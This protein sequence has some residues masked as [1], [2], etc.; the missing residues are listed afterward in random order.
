MEGIADVHHH[1]ALGG[2]VQLGEDHTVEI[3]GLLERQRL[4]EGVLACGGVQH[5]Q[6]LTGHAG[7]LPVDD[8]ADLT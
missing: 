3:A 8:L 1:A 7:Q 6:H 2:A 5:Q 4:S